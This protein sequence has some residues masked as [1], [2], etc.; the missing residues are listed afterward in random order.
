MKKWIAAGA[1]V[2]G[3]EAEEPGEVKEAWKGTRIGPRD[4]GL[5]KSEG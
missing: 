3:V 1:K 5:E 4:T 2:W